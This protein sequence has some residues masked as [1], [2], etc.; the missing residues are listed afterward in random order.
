MSITH[1][2]LCVWGGV[3]E[4]GCAQVRVS[5]SQLGHQASTERVMRALSLIPSNDHIA[6][7]KIITNNKI[8]VSEGM[9]SWL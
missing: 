9:V 8:N 2:K 4:C 5:R 3:C 6:S 1:I 7:L